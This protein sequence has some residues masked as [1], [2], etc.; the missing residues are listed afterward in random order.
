MG[1]TGAAITL[2]AFSSRGLLACADSSFSIRIVRELPKK[3]RSGD[4]WEPLGKIQAHIAPI[5]GIQFWS[6]PSDEKV[7]H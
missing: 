3:T 1:F 4:K 7:R 6:P 2:I 5:V